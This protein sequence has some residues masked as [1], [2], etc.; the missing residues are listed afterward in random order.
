MPAMRRA[1]QLLI[2][3]A[4]AALLATAAGPAGAAVAARTLA[5]PS[6]A[7]PG[8]ARSAAVTLVTGDKVLLRQRAGG[9]TSVQVIAAPRRGPRPSFQ[10]VSIRGDV[11]VIPADVHRLLGRVLDPDLFNVSELQ[12]M[13]YGDARAPSLPLI[14]QR[15]TTSRPAAL[16]A[17]SLRPVRELSSLRATAMRQPRA[18]AAKLGA[19][20]AT[21]T[22]TATATRTTGALAGV[23]RVWLDRRFRATELDPNLTQ[24]NAPAAWS[25]GLTGKGVKVAVLD[26]G[27]DTSHPDLAGG[28]VV[29]S[30]NFTEADSIIDHYGHGTHVA[31]I[32]AGTGARAAGARKGVAFEASLLNGKV[33]DDFGFGSESGIIAGMEWAARQ[34]AKVVNLSLGGEPTDGTDPMSQAVN[35]LT[36]QYRALFVVAAGNSGPFEQSVENPGAATAALTVGAVD[37]SDQVADFSGRGPRFGDYAMKPDITAPGVDIV[38]ARAAGTDLGEPVGQWY[39]RLTGTSMATPHVAGAAAILAQRWPGWTPAR[40]KAVLMG[41]ANPNPSASVYSQGGGRLDI[42]HAIGQRLITRRVNL[43]FGW[44]R[45]PQTGVQPVTKPLLLQDLGDAT[46]TVDLTAELDT[47]DGGAAPAGM[48]TVT[49]SGLTLAAGAQATA[50]VT[51]DIGPGGPGLYSGAVVATPATGPA[52]RTPLGLYKEPE[53]Y[54]LTLKAVGRDGRPAAIADAGVLNVGN[55]ELFADFVVFDEDATLTLRVAPGSYHIMGSVYAEDFQTI[56]MVGDPEVRVTG[57]T[58]FTLD[59][60][61]AKP[62]S[63]GI[64]GVATDPSLVD[65]GWTR[66]DET[67]NFGLLASISAGRARHCSPSRPTSRPG[68][69]SSR[70]SC[71]PGCC[72]PAP[73]LRPPPR[74]C[75]TCSCTA[76]RSPTR[77]AGSCP[78]PSGPGWPG[79]TVTTVPSTTMPTTRTC[80]SA[81]RRCSSSPSGP[82]SRSP[83]PGPGSST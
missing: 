23:S 2:L 57:A 14:V 3:L 37:A 51:V 56:S 40:L 12:R 6:L 44:F 9:R 26:T 75:G 76:A 80:G 24:V 73:A 74:P 22:T 33:L 48:V 16:A 78:P 34:R 17:A 82:T 59:A 8:Q 25:A 67:G 10:V 31:S 35:R 4:V 63:V 70:S 65:L 29:A 55:G 43:D 1:R 60:R 28:K 19:A 58:T 64:E 45:Y 66:L 50:R 36:S 79:S 20:L 7:R 69:A 21:T 15:R 61:R 54:D 32:V 72:R 71:E 62:V 68:W 5:A 83:C 42:G 41:T 39:T 27:I 46:T 49:P 38:A 18:E 30:A 77:R 47:A 81:S 52:V 11:H 53:R 13:G